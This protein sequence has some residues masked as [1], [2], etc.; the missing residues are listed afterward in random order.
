MKNT[1]GPITSYSNFNYEKGARTCKVSVVISRQ[2]Q[3]NFS[4][5]ATY[6]AASFLSEVS[7]AP[8]SFWFSSYIRAC[9]QMTFF[10]PFVSVFLSR[11]VNHQDRQL[12]F[13]FF[14]N[15]TKHKLYINKQISSFIFPV[16][17]QTCQGPLLL[18]CQHSTLHS[19]N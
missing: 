3:D 10:P 12:H 15:Q 16:G 2:R 6:A 9:P 11:Y 7:R 17:C 18:N 8:L 5:V 13:F 1:H 14:S 4:D 19:P